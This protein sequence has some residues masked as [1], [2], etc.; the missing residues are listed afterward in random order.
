MIYLKGAVEETVEEIQELEDGVRD[1]IWDVRKNKDQA[2]LKYNEKIDGCHRKELLVEKEEIQE[3]YRELDPQLIEDIKKSAENVRKFAIEQKNS[4][5]EIHDFEVVPGVFLG[6]KILPIENVG[7]YV[8][9]GV[10][11]LYSTAIMLVVPAKVAR[12]NRIVAC[13][14]PM[15][16]TNKIHPATLVAMDIAGADE[17]YVMGGAHSIAAMAYGI[18]QMDPVDK[19]V[20]PGNQ[21]VT[22]AKRQCFGQIGIDFLAGPSEVL[23]I[24]DR[25]AK[26]EYIAAD[27]LAQCEH[28]KKAKGILITDDEKLGQDV[29]REVERQLED[30]PTK[31]IAKISW[32]KNG[33]VILVDSLEEAYEIS[34]KYA[35]EHLELHLRDEKAA[36]DKLINYGSLF[37]GENAAEVFGDYISGTNHTLPTV[38]AARYTGGVSVAMFTKT[39]T[40]QRIDKRGLENIGEIAARM[41]RGEGL[42]GHARSAEKR[43]KD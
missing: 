14:P 42:I 13:S 41:A 35:P 2:I 43:L 23:I 31:E 12:V 3:A 19:I 39:A 24:G 8:P 7:C 30:L 9:G 15:H 25:N 5:K 22:E 40:N 21:F 28:D 20:G 27:L 34:N 4:S 36:I 1:I 6:H 37:I 11:P 17:I 33:E 10:Y 26:P 32:E 18:E 29:I 38:K 16:S